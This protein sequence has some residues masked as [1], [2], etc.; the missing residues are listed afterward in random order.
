[1]KTK[2]TILG[3]I[4]IILL[5]I[6][7]KKE[8][9]KKTIYYEV[10]G[11]GYVFRHDSIG[12][13]HPV[14]GVD[15]KV[16]PMI[17]AEEVGLFSFETSYSITENYITDENGMFHNVRFVKSTPGECEFSPI[18]IG[19]RIPTCV[20]LTHAYSITCGNKFFILPLEDVK[21]ATGMIYLDT[22]FIR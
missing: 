9:L 14:Q 15:V 22:L 18:T 6:S 7:C 20:Y 16:G 21:N 3:I 17:G 8:E 5:C 11:T 19:G 10:V 1:M 4:T 13:S 12:L 2:F